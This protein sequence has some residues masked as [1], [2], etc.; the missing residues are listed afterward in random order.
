MLDVY[1]RGEPSQ[2]SDVLPPGHESHVPGGRTLDGTGSSERVDDT[3]ES[4]G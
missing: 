4:I 1:H 2:G 3:T